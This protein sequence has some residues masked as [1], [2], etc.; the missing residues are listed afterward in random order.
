MSGFAIREVTAS[1]LRALDCAVTDALVEGD[2]ITCHV[3]G[4]DLLGPCIVYRPET[5]P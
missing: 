1:Y 2:I 3:S 5:R 4:D